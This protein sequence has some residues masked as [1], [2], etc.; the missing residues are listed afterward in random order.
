M[1]IKSD[2]QTPNTIAILIVDLAEFCKY[3][4]LQPALPWYILCRPFAVPDREP[5]DTKFRDDG[6]AP[7]APDIPTH[8]T[9]NTASPLA[10]SPDPT[11]HNTLP[12]AR[13][14]WLAPSHVWDNAELIATVAFGGDF[15][16][17]DALSMVLCREAVVRR[18]YRSEML[19]LVYGV[20]MRALG[21]KIQHTEWLGIDW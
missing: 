8:P 11:S 1:Y 7:A 20:Q 12:A 18:L 14:S 10:Y 3:M 16:L 15:S 13:G 4:G 2:V 19:Q 17:R 9:P 6:K 21:W 5:K